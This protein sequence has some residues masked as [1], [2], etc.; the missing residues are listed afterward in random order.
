[1]H[2]GPKNS[3]RDFLKATTAGAALAVAPAVH[4]A[5][6]DT[7]RVGLVGCGGRGTG[8]ATQALHADPAVRLVAVGDM[9]ADRLDASLSQLKSDGDISAKIDVKDDHRF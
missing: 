9:F 5:G 6:G 2:S 4:A 3:R 8:A 7:L 1:M